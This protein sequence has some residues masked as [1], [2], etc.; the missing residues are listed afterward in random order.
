MIP[1][2]NNPLPYY[3]ENGSLYIYAAWQTSSSSICEHF[4]RKKTFGGVAMTLTL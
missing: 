2:K 4:S 1:F 3:L